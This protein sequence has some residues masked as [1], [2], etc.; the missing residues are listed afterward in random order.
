MRV[1]HIINS[2][3]DGGAEAVLYRLCLFDKEN[4]HIVISLKDQEKYGPLLS[5]IG[6]D[7]YT[8]NF[9]NL[10][11]KFNGLF[12]LINLIRRLKPDVVQ[13]WM[14]HAN[15]LGGLAAKLAGIKNIFWGI[16]HTTL[17]KSKTKKSTL[18]ISSINAIL[19]NYIPKKII[20]CAKKSREIQESVGFNKNRGVVV[21]NGY[22]VKSFSQNKDLKYI[23]N[24]EMSIPIDTFIIGYVGRYHPQKDIKNLIESLALL[25]KEVSFN[26]ILV[27]QNLD[28]NNQELVN[29]I[30]KSKL[31][32]LVHLV[33]QKDD[34]PRFMNGIDLFVLSSRF[35]E[36]FPNVLNEAMACGTPCV[37]T[38]VGDSAVI[39]GDTGWVVPPNNPESLS[40]AI[41]SAMQEKKSDHI[42]WSQREINC[43]ERII[44]NFSLE[45]MV[46]NYFNVWTDGNSF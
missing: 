13:T 25:N 18:L 16:H 38:N 8:V 43:K 37:T 22:D 45:R 3:G 21:Y 4:K 14:I 19:S 12:K 23:L 15:F 29:I 10:I 32:D 26:A 2:L 40:N 33:G 28:N 39:V 27:G 7:V 30:N 41:T 1:L 20:Y 36:A 9:S 46:N 31:D 11:I 35:G 42:L 17:L 5:K 6:V 44:K 34:I 24:E